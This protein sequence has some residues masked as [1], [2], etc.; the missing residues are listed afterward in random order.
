MRARLIRYLAAA[1]ALPLLM[2]PKLGAASPLEELTG[3]L[4]SSCRETFCFEVKS[5]AAFRSLVRNEYSLENVTLI[6]RP[7]DL[8]SAAVVIKAKTARTDSNWNL[9]LLQTETG[10]AIFDATTGIIDK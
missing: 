5:D 2:S 7:M 3:V 1:A 9:W 6:V 10:V 4:V 8:K